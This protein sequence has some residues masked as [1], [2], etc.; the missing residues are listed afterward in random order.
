MTA[1]LILSLLLIANIPNPNYWTFAGFVVAL[2]VGFPFTVMSQLSTSPMLD[3]I[4]PVHR[5]G[6]V[7]GLNMTCYNISSAIAPWLIGLLADATSTNVM[8]WTGIGISFGAGLVNAPLI[9]QRRFR[10]NST[11]TVKSSAVTFPNHASFKVA[12][13]QRGP[14][15]G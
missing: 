5:R 1:I 14:L 6:F 8:L 13:S 10:P 15:T 9:C 2:C 12:K 11:L 4:S 3:R 7:Q